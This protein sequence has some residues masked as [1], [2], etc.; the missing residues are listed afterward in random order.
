M[1]RLRSLAAALAWL[2]IAVV[3]A[4]GAAGLATAVGG[5]P[6]GVGRDE[7]TSTGD[8]AIGPGLAAAATDLATLTAHLTALAER[9]RTALAALVATDLELL[10]QS[11]DAGTASLDRMTADAARL[12]AELLAL[13][14]ITGDAAAPLAPDAATRLGP[15]TRARFSTMYDALTAVVELP[16]GWTR[17]AGGALAAQTLT[18]QLIEH[19]EST[20]KAAGLVKAQDYAA[21][22]TA[23][24]ASDG[25]MAS[26][27]TLRDQ[28]ANSV[29]VS[30]LTEWLDRNADYDAALRRLCVALRDADGRVTPDLSAAIEAEQ[31]ARDRLPP[32]TRGVTVI[33]AELARGGLNEVAIAIDEARG[34]LDRAVDA[35]GPAASPSRATGPSASPSAGP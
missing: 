19:D 2:A 8:A 20:A 35:A 3:F 30:T 13:P 28:L 24:D 31:A 11:V 12:R 6:G 9:S 25:I 33:L 27:R 26:S 15:A 1:G 32:D 14:G 18:T 22:L 7:L 10:R 16:V 4:L 23:L 5:Q 29:D 34:R 21:A 17:F